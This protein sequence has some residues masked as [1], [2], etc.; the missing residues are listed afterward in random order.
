L[1]PDD[2]SKYTVKRLISPTD[3]KFDLDAAALEAAM[4]D[5]VAAWEA[6]TADMRS[7]TRPE[8]PSGPALRKV[9]SP[10]KGLLLLYM[11]DPI[12][13]KL[14]YGIPVV[15]FAISFPGDKLNPTEGVEYRANLVYIG[16]EISD[17]E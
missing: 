2:P 16:K 10:E 9:R 15:G 12:E 11:L 4:L 7:V 1:T 17:E 3:E 8:S 6:K 5:T 14:P 13:A